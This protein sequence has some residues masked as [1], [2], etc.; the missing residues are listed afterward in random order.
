MELQPTDSALFRTA[1]EGLKDFLPEAQLMITPAGL[2]ISGMDAAHVGFVA[3][4]LAAADCAVLKVPVPQS[5]GLPLAILA[6]VLAPVGAGD[7][8]TLRSTDE[9]LTVSF[10]NEKLKKKTVCNVPLLD[11]SVDALE[12]PTIDYSVTVQAKTSDIGALF[13]EVGAFGD[14]LSLSLDEDGF[15]VVAKGVHGTMTQTLENTEDREMD[16]HETA[17]PPAEPVGF[18]TKYLIAMLKCALAPQIKLELN[19]ATPMRIS[20]QVG[21]G[22]SL[23]FHLAPKLNEDS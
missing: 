15:K 10:V 22:S 4:T 5:L 2:S 23:V 18:G 3:Y 17:A 19:E 13:K 21:T 8:V 16:F 1:I 20:Y 11:I 6:K 14:T 7:T 12:I 9:F